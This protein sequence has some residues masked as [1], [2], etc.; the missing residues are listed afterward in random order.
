MRFTIIGSQ[1]LNDRS[2]T[3]GPIRKPCATNDKL[4]GEI[5][6]E[7]TTSGLF[8]TAGAAFACALSLWWATE[9]SNLKTRRT[10]LA[11][12][13]AIIVVIGLVVYGFCLRQYRRY[14]RNHSI[15]TATAMVVNAQAFDSAAYAASSF[16]QEV[17]L[18]ARGYKLSSPLPPASRLDDNKVQTRRC[19]RLRHALRM[20]LND[21]VIPHIEAYKS[22]HSFAN[23]ANLERYYDMYEISR[24]DIDELLDLDATRT[25]DDL[26]LLRVLKTDLHRL[27]MARKMSLCSILALDADC[28]SSSLGWNQ[29]T[30]IMEDISNR[31]G[32]S[33][34]A[35][36]DILDEEQYFSAPPS[37]R[38]PITPNRER[39]QHHVRRFANL[40]QGLRGLQAKMHILREESDRYLVSTDE[41]TQ[42]GTYFLEQY[43]AIGNDMKQLLADWEDGRAALAVNIG[44][45]ERRRSSHFTATPTNLLSRSSSRS[46]S[47]GGLTAVGGSPND[48]LKVFNEVPISCD[49]GSLDEEVY[50]ALALPRANEGHQLSREERIAKMRE[51][52]IRLAVARE[53]SD[54]SRFMVKEL[55]TVIKARPHHRKTSSPMAPV[56][57]RIAATSP[58]PTSPTLWAPL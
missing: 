30:E 56:P 34:K 40:S 18:I 51:E 21:L 8:Y 58:I 15:H 12:V 28:R 4:P 48:A 25:E 3:G 22:L 47:L 57:V 37:P 19:Q 26:E 43:D 13:S 14:A 1:L 52:R 27:F 2:V 7:Y 55:E 49:M 17:E 42:L 36:E 20:A 46:S 31:T 29:I 5:P 44:R 35:L 54:A 50:E 38:D 45:N 9:T 41:A 33:A 23:A 53:R 32:T 39:A 11:I 24:S 10:R 6:I 16:I